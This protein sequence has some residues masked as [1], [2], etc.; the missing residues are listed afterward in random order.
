MPERKLKETSL[1]QQTLALFW[2]NLLLKWRRKWPSIL[3]WIQHLA[4]VFLML[5]I[6]SIGIYITP[7]K[8]KYVPA[9]ILG[10]LDAPNLH[11]FVVGYV[12]TSSTSS[13]IME[14]VAKSIIMP[15]ATVKEYVDEKQLL[16]DVINASVVAVSFVDKFSYQ[17]RYHYSQLYFPND[18]FAYIGYCENGSIYCNP[19]NYWSKGFLSLQASI[20]SAIIEV[21]TNQSV[22]NTMASLVAMKMKSM[23][24]QTKLYFHTAISIFAMPMC[25]VSLMYLLSL[26]VTRERCE[27]REILKMMGLRDLAFWLS[28]GLLYIC[29]ILIIANLMTLIT[30]TYIFVESSYGIIMLLFFLYGIALMS[31]TFM[32]SSLIRNP[33]IT[34]I[35]GFFITV[36]LSA[37]SLVLMSRNVPRALEVLLSIFP[38]FAFSVGIIQSIHLESDFQGVYF[39]DMMEES[40]HILSS[41]ISLVLDSIFYMTL[42]L[43]FDKILSDKHGA[44]YEPFFFLKSSFWSKE[45][46]S[47]INIQIHGSSESSFD[48]S[49]EKVHADLHGK[50]AIRINRIKKIYCDKDKNINA[51]RGLD[52]NIYEGQ[53]TALLGHSGAGKTTLLNILSGMCPASDG[54]VSV[55]NYNLNDMRHLEEIRKRVGFCPQFDVKFDPLKVKENLTVFAMIKGIPLKQVAQEVQHIL[56][57]LQMN[58]I[59]NTDVNKLSG[60]Q[61][62]KLSFA[63]A[64]LGDPQVLLLDEPTAGLDPCSRHNIWTILKER[65]ADRV[66]LFSTQFMDEADILAD[67]KA[68]I[69]NGRLRCVGSSLFLKRKWGI[70]YHLR[71]QVSPPCDTE[72][73][74]SIIKQHIPNAKL[75]TQN[76]EELTYILPF[77]NMDVFPDLFL[78]LDGHVGGSIINYGVSMTTLDDVF[79]KLEGEAEIDKGDYGVFSPEPGISDDRDEYTVAMEDSLL[80]M[81][82]S[83]NVTLSGFAL[84][85]QQVLAVARIRFLKL[86]HD[87]KSFRSILLLLAIFIMALL[88]ITIMINI[89]FIINSWELTPSLY[90]QRPGDRIHNYYTELRIYNNTGSPIEDF[91]GAVRKQNIEL[92]VLNGKYDVFTTTYRGAIEISQAEKGY[93]FTIVG[94]TKA[95]NG[96]PV[97]LNIISNALLETFKSS[98]HIRVWANHVLDSKMHPDGYFTLVSS[99]FLTMFAVGLPP[100]FAMSSIDDNRLNARSQ[101]RISGLFP[102]AYWFGQA[103]VDV[104]LYWILLFLM[105]AVV[106]AFNYHFVFG[107]WNVIIMIIGIISFGISMVLYVY[108]ISFIFG[109][110][111]SHHDSWS[112]F[113]VIVAILPFIMEDFFIMLHIVVVFHLLFPPSTLTG[114][115]LYVP[116]I[117]IVLL[118]GILWCFETK[119]RNKC[120]NKDPIFRIFRGKN[121]VKEN[122][123]VLDNDVDEEVLAERERVKSFV[124]SGNVGEKPVIIVNNLRKEYKVKKGGSIFKKKRTAATKNIS[125][126]VRKGE[127]L[128]LLGPNGAGK[129]TSINVLAGEEIPT[130]GEVMLNGN[131]LDKS[132]C[133]YGPDGFLGYCPQDNPLWPNLTVKEHLEAYAAVKGMKKDDSDIAIKRVCEA[134]ELKNHLQIAARK[135]SAGISRK[136]WFAIGMLGNP[137][138]VLLDEPS[139]GLDPKGQQRIWRAIRAAIKNKDRG[140]ILTTHYMEEAEAVCDRVAIMVS[141]KLRCIGSIQQLK[142][143]YGKDYCLEIKVKD[144][145]QVDQIHNEVLRIFPHAARQDR[146]SLLLVYKIPMDNINSLSQAFLH[147]EEAKR[148]YNI[149]EYSFSQS[150]LE[151][152][153]ISICKINWSMYRPHPLAAGLVVRST[154]TGEIRSTAPF[155]LLRQNFQ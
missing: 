64:I 5:N 26:Y 155:E 4:F 34:A 19:T 100:H 7:P 150:T 83:G 132:Q 86:R 1:C 42:T 94:N 37:L 91:V 36:F 51:L 47:P 140:A 107:F 131:V 41:Y 79:L 71:M 61:R 97:L 23:M 143:K 108:N 77:E 113:F 105:T 117:H 30:K 33:R 18:Y 24:Q 74:T 53:I 88:M 137:S 122:P 49:D 12:N 44:K 126:C 138:I 104:V 46:P 38:Q 32:L 73:M 84:W 3:E 70:G 154:V 13:R 110:G 72:L 102:S 145:Y 21:T 25:Y 136:V 139:T 67:R 62:R 16:E 103:L 92:E 96:L 59:A 90:F 78:H 6:I 15:G 80:L 9:E 119:F 58:D 109:K 81:S 43:Y 45:R 127:V 152:V 2:K 87:S 55:Y 75:T 14:K 68:V 123:E 50:E 144:S 39:S 101:L 134:L 27:M 31:F 135:L 8:E 129:T 11:S 147:L 98:E 106:F 125:L 130:A 48:E 89:L 148:V 95:Y 120:Q 10:R 99:T 65:K 66:T 69:S 56:S 142:S 35:A 52:L 29:Y 20:D 115:M 118:Y 57:N 128:G 85:R 114:I 93:H 76:E 63:I 141:G 153:T 82:D 151:Q 112:L 124:T 116:F 121:K 22:W 17:I 60:G 111:K 54:S 28:W 133:T 146:F 149:E 40:S